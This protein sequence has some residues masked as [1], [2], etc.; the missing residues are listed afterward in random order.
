MGLG[1]WGEVPEGWECRMRGR[2]PSGEGDPWRE[3]WEGWGGG[4]AESGQWAG[5]ERWAV[6]GVGEGLRVLVGTL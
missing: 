6:N 2:Q 5:M 4:G 3:P 1:T